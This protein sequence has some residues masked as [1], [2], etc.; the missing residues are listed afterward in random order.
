[1]TRLIRRF[2][3]VIARIPRFSQWLARLYLLIREFTQALIEFIAKVT[4][5]AFVHL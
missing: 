1:M 2:R 5:Q 4:M 3:P